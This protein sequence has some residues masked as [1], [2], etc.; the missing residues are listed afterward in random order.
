MFGVNL[1]YKFPF[2]AGMI[3]A[4][5]AAIVCVATGTTARSVGIG[6]IPGILSI[7]TQ[8]ML[9][10]AICMLIAIAVPFLLTVVFGKKKLSYANMNG[11]D[12]DS[13]AVEP[14]ETKEERS[15]ANIAAAGSGNKEMKAFLSGKVIPLKEVG[16]GVF[17]EGIMGEGLAIFPENELLYSPVD[18]EITAIMPDSRH[19]CGLK[20]D[21]GM[22]VLLHIGLDTVNMKGDG[23]EYMIK[24]GQKVKAGDEL[25]RFSKEKIKAA[26]YQDVTIFVVTNPAVAKNLTF[27]TGF[28]AKAKDSVIASFQ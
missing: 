27:K 16:D 22:E 1:K 12:A 8:Y 11:D 19:A 26:G 4:A 13:V 15:M 10:F 25:I 14:V 5:L 17:S 7:K 2:L 3:G 6:G 20:M 23:F 28:N 24:A 21:N 18:A 9:S